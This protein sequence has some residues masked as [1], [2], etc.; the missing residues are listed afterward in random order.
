MEMDTDARKVKFES[1]LKARRE[2]SEKKKLERAEERENNSDPT[3]NV[4]IFWKH[5]NIKK[6]EVS[7]ILNELRASKKCKSSSSRSEV[8]TKLDNLNNT[9]QEMQENAADGSLYLAAYDTR[10]ASSAIHGLL[11]EVTT[12]RSTL[13][14]RS[15]FSFKKVRSKQEVKTKIEVDSTPTT[16]T[17]TNSSNLDLSVGE[18]VLENQSDQILE[19]VSDRSNGESIDDGKDVRLSNLERCTISIF[20][21]MGAIRMNDLKDCTVYAGPVA[22]SAFFENCINCTLVVASRQ[23]RIHDSIGCDFYLQV[24]SNPIV[25]DCSGIRVSKYHMSYTDI[26]DHFKVSGLDRSSNYWDN[27][28]DFKWHRVQHSPN[29]SILPNDDIDTKSK[30]ERVTLKLL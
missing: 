7:S 23:I 5:F 14:P 1:R 2:A 22:G 6:D 29:W 24:S 11:E 8:T 30:D 26:E 9:I 4:A 28:Q 21:V 10:A 19:L 15:K 13:I 16:T 12:V 27:V 17:T 18:R 25:E 3:E 20:D